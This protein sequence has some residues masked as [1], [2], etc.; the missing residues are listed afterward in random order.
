MSKSQL[1]TFIEQELDKLNQRIDLK[2]LEGES[3]R[4]DAARHKLLLSQYQK[5]QRK[6]KMKKWKNMFRFASFL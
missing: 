1:R 6:E 4:R 5:L 3:F 2:I